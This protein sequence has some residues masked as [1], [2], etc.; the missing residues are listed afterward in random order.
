MTLGEASKKPYQDAL[1]ELNELDLLVLIDFV[2]SKEWGV[3]VRPMEE[4]LAYGSAAVGPLLKVLSDGLTEGGEDDTISP[5]PVVLLGELR[6]PMA[7]PALAE[8]MQRAAADDVGLAVAAAEALAKIGSAAL[9]AVQSLAASGTPHQ[10]HWAYYTAGRI[11]DVD[12][13]NW[14]VAALEADPELVD[15]VALALSDQGRT[16]AIEPIFRTLERAEYWQLPELEDA[17][18]LLH[19]IRPIENV[20][21]EDW[22]LRYRWHP[23]LGQFTLHWATIGA[24][25]LGD[26][27]V[28]EG[29]APRARRTLEEILSDRRQVDREPCDCCGVPT[30]TS[31]GLSVC[32]ETAGSIPVLQARM[33]GNVAEEEGLDDLFDVLDEVERRHALSEV[34]KTRS[35]VA[36]RRRQESN[37]TGFVVLRAGCI[38]LIEQGIETVARGLSRLRAE[39]RRASEE[40]NS[41][42]PTERATPPAASTPRTGRNDPCPCGSGRKFK[43]CCGGR[44]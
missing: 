41:P 13:F 37:Q 16:E 3:P 8:V 33:L 25:V 6:D 9:P 32:P 44:S 24:I 34:E 2:A 22:R 36:S 35:G 11:D 14:L 20:P 15:S 12:S 23:G 5:W 31:T 4:I 19:G 39:A 21:S 18:A 1:K 29:R 17:L 28:L 38:W 10:R 27:R 40:H 26:K 43:K 7:A 30:W 42:L